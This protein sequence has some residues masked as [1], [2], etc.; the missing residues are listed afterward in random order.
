MYPN[1]NQVNQ[2]FN[3]GQNNKVVEDAISSAEQLAN[4]ILNPPSVEQRAARP[5]EQKH[6]HYYEAPSYWYSP[7]LYP[8][9]STTIINN[10]GSA[11]S[12]AAEQ[13]EDTTDR[14]LIGLACA[15]LS[16][17]VAYFVGKSLAEL[18]NI[19]REIKELKNAEAQLYYVAGSQNSPKIETAQ[20]VQGLQSQI[21]NE[22]H[23]HAKI[24][25]ALKVS[26]LA[27]SI[28]GLTGAIIAGSA[29]WALISIGLISLAITGIGFLL[30]YAY[31][32]HNES[33]KVLAREILKEVNHL[34][35]EQEAS[36]A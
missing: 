20:K 24:S 35:Q 23:T 26:L 10:H 3:T 25:L 33:K 12:A 9:H 4:T 5:S 14:V 15:A 18:Q 28:L 31:D 8:S 13:R 2:F 34:S 21:L 16:A 30:H 1:I 6:Y 22:K 19:N 32:S 36:V 7:F 17:C 29:G 11:A 27:S